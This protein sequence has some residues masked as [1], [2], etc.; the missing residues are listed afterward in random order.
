M[1]LNTF[2]FL[3]Q[4]N[5][6]CPKC[7]FIIKNDIDIEFDIEFNNKGN[8]KDLLDEY[9]GEKEFLNEGKINY[10]CKKCGIMPKKLIEMKDIYMEPEVLILYFDNFAILDDYL[11][12]KNTRE[13]KVKNFELN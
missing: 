12:I 13:K 1:I 4:R 6:K 11:E 2:Y 8:V 9:F 5:Y 3:I 10:T 7:N